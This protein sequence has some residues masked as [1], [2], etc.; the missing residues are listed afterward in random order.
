MGGKS[1]EANAYYVCELHSIKFK[2]RSMS[3]KGEENEIRATCDNNDL[4]TLGMC[5]IEITYFMLG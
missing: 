1:G 2:R 3:P 4:N 5:V